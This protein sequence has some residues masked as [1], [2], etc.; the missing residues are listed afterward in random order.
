MLLH[1]GLQSLRIGSV[2]GILRE[3]DFILGE[4]LR[5]DGAI[6][7]EEVVANVEHMHLRIFEPP[8]DYVPWELDES[9][10]FKDLPAGGRLAFA[11]RIILEKPVS[12]RYAR[13]KCAGRKGWGML[14]SEIQVFDTVK[15][16]AN[17]PPLVVLPPLAR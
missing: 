1:H 6:S 15:V 16:D 3:L 4:Q 2:A 5:F 12:A 10:L 8:A 7:I 17:V 9:L 11:F 14:R 13:V